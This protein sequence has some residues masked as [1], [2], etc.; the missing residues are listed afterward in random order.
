MLK[1]TFFCYKLSSTRCLKTDVTHLYDN[2]LLVRREIPC[3]LVWAWSGFGMST[4]RDPSLEIPS[5]DARKKP[6]NWKR[7]RRGIFF[8]TLS[9]SIFHR[10][11]IDR[12]SCS[13][14]P[15]RS[16]IFSLLAKVFYWPC[17]LKFGF[18][19]HHC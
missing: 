12:T 2:D 18:F 9:D 8:R 7:L 17:W 1:H 15:V 14:L 4:A 19:W 5:N 11:H 16:G 10:F 3:L 13:Q 6:S